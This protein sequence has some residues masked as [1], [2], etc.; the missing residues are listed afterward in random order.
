MLRKTYVGVLMMGSIGACAPVEGALP[1]DTKANSSVIEESQCHAYLVANTE[2]CLSKSETLCKEAL[3]YK[4]PM[5]GVE[6]PMCEVAYRP[7][8]HI[9][10]PQRRVPVGTRALELPEFDL[11]D[12][13]PLH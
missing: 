1:S 8:R 2:T 7:P 5:D 10:Y 4:V 3:K 13:E 12:L 6:Q 11:K 9:G